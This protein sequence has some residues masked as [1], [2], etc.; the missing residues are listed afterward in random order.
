VVALGLIEPILTLQ[1]GVAN[2]EVPVIVFS[3]QPAMLGAVAVK[4][5]RDAVEIGKASPGESS[6]C[7]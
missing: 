7:S 2:G 5:G 4:T 1:R 6:P 3:R